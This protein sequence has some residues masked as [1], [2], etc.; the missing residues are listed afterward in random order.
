MPAMIA[1]LII[2]FA[3]FQ[4][5]KDLLKKPLYRALFIWMFVILLTGTIFYRHVQGWSWIDSLYFSVITL[6]TVGYGDL[7]PT[8]E[9]SKI[10]TWAIYS[11]G[12]VYSSPSP[13]C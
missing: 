11:S 13:A 6:A 3:L 5:R 8:T 9:W 1:P 4:E 7:T 10:F 2:M 12:S